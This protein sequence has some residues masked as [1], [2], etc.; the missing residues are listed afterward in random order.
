MNKSKQTNKQTISIPQGVVNH[1]EE[2]NREVLKLT[3]HG[4]P[5]QVIL[6]ENKNIV[7]ENEVFGEI[8]IVEK[9]T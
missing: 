8:A 4:L 9:D 1:A 6:K 2:E 5:N 3:A 7:D